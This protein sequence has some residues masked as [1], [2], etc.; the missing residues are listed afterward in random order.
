VTGPGP[1]R[2]L[3][4]RAHFLLAGL[5]GG[6][7]FLLISAVGL[8][9]VALTRDRN[10]PGHFAHLWSA[11][12]RTLL[13]WRVSVEHCERLRLDHAVVYMIRHQSNLDTVTLGLIYPFK[14]VILGKKEIRKIP[15]FGWFF[16]A[17]GNIFVD[18]KNPRRAVESLREAADRIA[19]EGLS[20]W[21][22][23]EGTRNATRQLRPFKKGA[24]HVAIDAQIP[25]LP[26]VS[27]PL[28]GLLDADR[29]MARPGR[30]RHRVLEEIPSAGLTGDDVDLLV[31]RVWKA[32]DEGQ[33]QLLEGA[34]PPLAG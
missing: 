10:A 31:D 17:T 3:L 22:F 8:V 28:D 5:L 14:T 32:M 34:A 24:F 15:I 30:L 12:M 29:W 11:V 6:L 33:R 25:I 23:P 19:R 2:R 16:A 27:G 9:Y 7:A 13:G 20:L 4:Y 1:L 18:R 26:I 21:V